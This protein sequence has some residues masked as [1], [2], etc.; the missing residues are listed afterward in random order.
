MDSDL[1][2]IQGALELEM[3]RNEIDAQAEALRFIHN[4]YLSEHGYADREYQSLW[5]TLA[6]FANN[7]GS[8]SSFP[9]S[10]CS[11]YY[12]GPTSGSVHKIVDDNAFIINTRNLTPADS[13]ILSAK[14][15]SKKFKATSLYPRIV[16]TASGVSGSN[17]DS[18][19]TELDATS[20]KT[21][22]Q[23]SSVEGIWIIAAKDATGKSSDATRLDTSEFFDFHIRTCWYAPNRSYP[24][25]IATIVR[26]YNPNAVEGGSS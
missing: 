16:Y 17:T 18:S 15:D 9:A 4:S 5:N 1:S 13:T 12:N 19:I 6:G 20:A 2:T 23:I 25:T 3:A 21:Y 7:P 24:T 14:K 8:I 10:Q 11:T 22:N 26:L